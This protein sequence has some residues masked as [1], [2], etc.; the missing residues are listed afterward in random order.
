MPSATTIAF[1][2]ILDSIA[3]EEIRR[4]FLSAIERGCDSV[5]F[6]LRATKDLD[7]QGLALLATVARHVAKHGRPQIRLVGVSVEMETVLNVTGLSE[8]YAVHPGVTPE[9]E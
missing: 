5:R 3:A 2:E 6:D 4:R 9:D 7:V 1:P 8:P